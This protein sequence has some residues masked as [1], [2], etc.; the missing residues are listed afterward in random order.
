MHRHLIAVKVS[1]ETFAD[2]RMELDGISFNKQRFKSLNAHTVE[3]GGSI[4]QNRMVTNHFFQDVPD[5]GI[6]ALKH[7]LS[8]LNRVGM[9]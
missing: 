1:I 8:A 3:R 5:F 6:L 4:E 2:K 9:A 7:F